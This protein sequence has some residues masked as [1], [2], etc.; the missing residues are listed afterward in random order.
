[1]K[2]EITAVSYCIA[3]DSVDALL[4]IERRDDAEAE[5]VW[6]QTLAGRIDTLDCVGNVEY[7]GHFGANIFFTIEGVAKEHKTTLTAIK[8][9]IKDYLRPYVI[10]DNA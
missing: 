8:R 9:L 1:M 3:L 7:N 4:F 6:T 10:K 5:H 2:V